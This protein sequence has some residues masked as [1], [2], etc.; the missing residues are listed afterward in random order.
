MSKHKRRNKPGRKN[1]SFAI[2]INKIAGATQLTLKELEE[3]ITKKEQDDSIGRKVVSPNDLPEGTIV[4]DS[5]N[6]HTLFNEERLVEHYD[7]IAQALQEFDDDFWSGK[8]CPIGD[9]RRD[10]KN[11]T[12]G[13]DMSCMN[14]IYLGLAMK[15]VEWSYVR[16]MWP[17]LPNQQPW[18]KFIGPRRN[19]TQITNMEGLEHVETNLSN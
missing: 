4:V 15:L 12:W 8:G 2:L 10:R 11:R 13:D 19:E 1:P 6:G 7:V 18:I 14:L 3:A 9:I 16:T 5:L 17:S